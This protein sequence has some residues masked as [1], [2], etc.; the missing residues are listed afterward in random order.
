MATAR[1]RVDCGLSDARRADSVDC[2][3]RTASAPA[4]ACVSV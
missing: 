4:F 2:P 1:K 3:I